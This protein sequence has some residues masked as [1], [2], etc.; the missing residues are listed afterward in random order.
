ME[1]DSKAF[2]WSFIVYSCFKHWF[3]LCLSVCSGHSSKGYRRQL[4][5]EKHT[6]RWHEMYIHWADKNCFLSHKNFW[7][8]PLFDVSQRSLTLVLRSEFSMSPFYFEASN[9]FLFILHKPG[10]N[11]PEWKKKGRR[12]QV[13]SIPA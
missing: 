7:F 6:N 5:Q 10:T 12:Y 13:F 9:L 2:L 1:T 4:W 11:V 3:R 8:S